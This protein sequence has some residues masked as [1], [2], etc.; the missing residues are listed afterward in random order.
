MSGLEQLLASGPGSFFFLGAP[1]FL[2]FAYFFLIWDARRA[3]SPNKDDG[4]IGLK[5][6]L[7][8]FIIIGISF[9][10]SGLAMVLHYALSGAKTGTP[11]LKQGLAGLIAGV[12]P[13][14]A[15]A[16]VFLPRTNYRQYTKA[17][18][19]AY[20]FLAAFG[21]SISLQSLNQLVSQLILSNPWPVISGALASLL[22]FAGIGF[23][24]LFRLG[25][26]SGWSAPVRPM[27]IAPSHSQG[28]PPQGGGYPPQGYP[29]QGYPQGYGGGQGG[30]GYGGPPQ[31]GGGGYPPGGGY[32]QR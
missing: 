21:V 7:Y 12:L 2:A 22:V 31:G 8:F 15:V 14:F 19:M 28:Y 30:G 13:I 17:A 16:V 5:L 20:G 29:P 32:Q 26:L 23:F 1:A 6:A 18:R 24:S 9:A 25:S 3:D 11:A 4:Q 10:A 27:P